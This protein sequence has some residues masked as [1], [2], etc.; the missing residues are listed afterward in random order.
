MNSGITGHSVCRSGS[1]VVDFEWNPRGMFT[2]SLWHTQA[3]KRSS[4]DTSV[5]SWQITGGR[6]HSCVCEMW[7]M[8]DIV[9]NS[10]GIHIAS[11]IT[12]HCIT[13]CIKMWSAVNALW[14]V[15]RSGCIVKC[16]ALWML[17]E[18][19]IAVDASWNVKRCGCIAKCEALWML[20]EMWSAVDALWNVKHYHYVGVNCE[21]YCSD[22]WKIDVLHMQIHV[23]KCT[24]VFSN[25]Y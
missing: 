4:R 11:Q 13:H 16:E 7:S 19:W 20:R 10:Q 8:G 25:R 3:M 17:R 14:Y 15:K 21:A 6:F 5:N 22:V 9:H 12:A 23:Y 1:C 24:C 18:M 2:I